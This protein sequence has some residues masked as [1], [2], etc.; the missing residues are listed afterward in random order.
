VTKLHLWFEASGEDG[1]GNNW[2][3]GRRE[4]PTEAEILEAVEKCRTGTGDADLEHVEKDNENKPA[5]QLQA[6]HGRYLLLLRDGDEV[7]GGGDIRSLINPNPVFNPDAPPGMDYF[8]GE[9]FSARSIVTDFTLVLQAFQEF[10]RTGNVSTKLM[11][12][13]Y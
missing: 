2:D 4:N 10:A 7:E 9:A 11:S 8:F 13:D 3:V 12:Y 5:L 1:D 6:D